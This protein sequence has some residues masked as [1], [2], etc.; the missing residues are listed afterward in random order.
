MKTDKHIKLLNKFL[1]GSCNTGEKKELNSM[2]DNP[3]QFDEWISGQWDSASDEIDSRVEKKIFEVIKSER[4]NSGRVFFT[5]FWKVAAI[6]LFI[7]TAGLTYSLLAGKGF[8]ESDDNQWIVNVDKGQKAN[9]ILPDGTKV[10]INSDSKITYNSSFNQRS[11]NINLEGEAYFEVAKN[12]EKPFVVHTSQMSV[13]ALGTAFNV[14][15]Y[16]DDPDVSATLVSGKVQVNTPVR[17]QL[18]KPNQR[19]V[20]DKTKDCIDVEF[21]A[22]IESFS[23]WRA[24]QLVFNQQDLKSI[25]KVLERH[26]NIR[27]VFE[28]QQLESYSFTG[29]IPNTSLESLLEIFT[30][31]S[32]LS[33]Q[34]KDSTIYLGVNK[35]TSKFYDIVMK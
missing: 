17:S 27:F 35:R 5:H 32:P 28:D 14:K 24:N 20:Y 15:A 19:L 6:L 26:Y 11:R 21:E 31:T 8:Y 3:N 29:T 12:E 4:K 18:L 16:K 13:R 10:W 9:M 1:D 30:M 2:L 33:Y 22:D 23:A 25:T 34:V 7:C